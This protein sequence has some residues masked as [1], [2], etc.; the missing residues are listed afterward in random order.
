MEIIKGKVLEGKHLGR[1]FGFPTVNVFYG[2]KESGVFAGRVF[3]EGNW[4]PAAINIG[5]RPTVDDVKNLCEAFILN[6][7]KDIEMGMEIEIELK[8][9]IRETKKF[10]N[11]EE[12][13]SQI[14]KDVEFVKTC[15][16]L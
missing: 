12:L 16:N 11:F 15:Y 4:H 5:K 2:G 7:D 10:P 3:V 1:Q 9:K 14:A 13:K 8:Q 6:W